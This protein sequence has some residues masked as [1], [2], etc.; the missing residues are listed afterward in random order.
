MR[1]PLD[2]IDFETFSGNTVNCVIARS[3]AAVG[4]FMRS[5]ALVLPFAGRTR[6]RGGAGPQAR[7]R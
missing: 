4:A 1:G 7:V 6:A 5:W 2:D 3:A